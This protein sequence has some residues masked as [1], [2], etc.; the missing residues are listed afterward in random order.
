MYKRIIAVII[1]VA[2]AFALAACGESSSKS[3]KLDEGT[4]AAAEAVQTA[5]KAATP[6]ADKKDAEKERNIRACR[7]VCA[8]QRQGLHEKF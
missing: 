3:V 4:P 6:E 2:A 8:V 5:E 7:G 1:A